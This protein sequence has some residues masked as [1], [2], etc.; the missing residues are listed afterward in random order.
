MPSFRGGGAERVMLTL[1]RQLAA[2]GCRTDLVVAQTEGPNRPLPSDGVDIVNLAARR[3]LAA[4]PGL[5]R[6]LR[7]ERPAV[8]LS[9][10]PHCN[11]IAIWARRLAGV[12]TRL[13][14][15]EHTTP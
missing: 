12:P 15:S 4:L 13:V 1:A 10:L 3:V 8:M 9:A 6:Y 5:V 11:V 2:S 7:E 14:V